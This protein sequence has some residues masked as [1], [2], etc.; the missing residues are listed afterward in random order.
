MTSKDIKQHFH[1]SESPFIEKINDIINRVENN[2][3]YYLTD[4]LN[5]RQIEIVKI[6]V[7]SSQL[8]AFSSSD[9]F[10][11]EYGRMIIAPAYYQLDE[12][13]FDLALVEIV[14]NPK[15]NKIKHSQILGA[16]IH[17]L[18]IQRSLLGD[19]L[20]EEGYAQVLTTKAMVTYLLNHINKIARASV[21]LKEIPISQLIKP[22]V[23]EILLD[24]TLSSL[25]LDRLIATVFKLSRSQA[26]KII[27][28]E[29]VKVNYRIIDKTSE[30]LNLDDL[31]SVR[32]FGRFKL[33]SDNGL[34]KNG[35]YKLTLS[36]T[37]QK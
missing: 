34:T 12:S 9:Y 19:I 20:V 11:T 1:P 25:R 6:L 33:L 13:D 32:G 36:K 5:P 15:F 30:T 31:V 29:K 18:G 26:I 24:V 2:Y 8:Q 21:N 17:E 28:S 7:A 14:Y 37:M 3:T 22:T 10:Q 16:L 23:D 35:K 27:E 4:F